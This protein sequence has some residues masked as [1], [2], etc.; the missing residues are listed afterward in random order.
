[1]FSY[2]I[3]T[4]RNFLHR[5]FFQKLIII[6]KLEFTFR[7]NIVKFIIHF[8]LVVIYLKGATEHRSMKWS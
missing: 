7:N 5:S 4:V 2:V 1:M 3:I 8:R 6:F